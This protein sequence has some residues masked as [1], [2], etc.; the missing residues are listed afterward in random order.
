MFVKIKKLKFEI[1]LKVKHS[2]LVILILGSRLSLNL[3]VSYTSTESFLTNLDL[4]T[5]FLII[6]FLIKKKDVKQAD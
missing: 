1:D 4:N 6:E 3:Q 5:E 2:V